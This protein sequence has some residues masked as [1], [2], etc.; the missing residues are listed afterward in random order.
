MA[1]ACMYVFMYV[2]MYVCMYIQKRLQRLVL[3]FQK[4][5]IES[6]VVAQLWFKH[7]L[8]IRMY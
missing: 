3:S 4:V 2:C 7:P 1:C 6:R 5:V 8:C